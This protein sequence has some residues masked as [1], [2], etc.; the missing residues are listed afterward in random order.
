MGPSR[1]LSYITGV[2]NRAEQKTEI[3]IP[4]FFVSFGFHVST[5]VVRGSWNMGHK[6]MFYL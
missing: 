3:F 6:L 1:W 2:R 5:Q 4:S